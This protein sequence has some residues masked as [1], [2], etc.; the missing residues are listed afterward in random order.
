[1]KPQVAEVRIFCVK[2]ISN[3]D[4]VSVFLSILIERRAEND[5]DTS[6]VK[7]DSHKK[8]KKEKKDKKDKKSSKKK[9]KVRI[10]FISTMIVS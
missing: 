8:S 10:S 1:M 9:N 4:H 6:K 3:H 7:D 2:I 5:I